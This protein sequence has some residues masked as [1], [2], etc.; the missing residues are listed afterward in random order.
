VF[1]LSLPELF[2]IVVLCPCAACGNRVK[3]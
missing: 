2:A 1:L 3:V